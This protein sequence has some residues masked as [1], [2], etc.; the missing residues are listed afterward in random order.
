MKLLHTAVAPTRY[1][2][3]DEAYFQHFNRVQE[4]S[5]RTI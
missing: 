2:N 1:D 5:D 3:Q 4:I